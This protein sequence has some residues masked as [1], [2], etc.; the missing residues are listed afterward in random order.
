MCGVRWRLQL[1]GNERWR[2]EL[3]CGRKKWLGLTREE[4]RRLKRA[5]EARQGQALLRVGTG[6]E[7]AEVR[8]EGT[9]LETTCKGIVQISA[10]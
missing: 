10:D 8:G 2:L 3:L 4:R 1:P 7:K 9:R 6:E 5:C